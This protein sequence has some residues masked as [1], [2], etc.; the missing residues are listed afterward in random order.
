[1]TQGFHSVCS[2]NPGV[3]GKARRHRR[4]KYSEGCDG[5]ILIEEDGMAGFI[6]AGLCSALMVLGLPAGGFAVEA[7]TAADKPAVTAEQHKPAGS[8][9]K[10]GS[11]AAG[12][13][14]KPSSQEEVQTRG[15]FSKKKKKTVGGAAGHTESPDQGDLSTGGEFGAGK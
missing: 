5:S 14:V 4:R 1:M 15:L 8:N 7:G 2:I 12:E 11:Q 6:H 9:A 13:S 10:G 3:C